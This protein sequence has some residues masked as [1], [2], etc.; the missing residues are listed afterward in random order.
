MAQRFERDHVV[1]VKPLYSE[2]P[3]G[4]ADDEDY[5]PEDD[6]KA[7]EGLERLNALRKTLPPISWG[8]DDL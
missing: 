8:T 5:P 4:A 1:E 2:Y 6:T 3:P 7:R